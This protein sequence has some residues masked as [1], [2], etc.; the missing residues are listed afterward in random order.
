MLSSGSIRNSKMNK[1]TREF[2]IIQGNLQL[3]FLYTTKSYGLIKLLFTFGV[4]VAQLL[5]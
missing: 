1:L 2:V 3:F 4:Y 5:T